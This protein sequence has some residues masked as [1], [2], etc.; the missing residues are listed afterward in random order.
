MSDINVQI[1]HGYKLKLSV[2]FESKLLDP[3]ILT[4]DWYQLIRYEEYRDECIEKYVISDDLTEM[5]K[6]KKW[7]IYILTSSQEDCDPDTSYCFIFNKEQELFN[8]NA[9]DYETGTVELF[10]EQPT[11]DNDSMEGQKYDIH[12]I[13]ESSY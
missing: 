11:N 10:Q 13:V 8:G 4:D 1:L 12:W 6:D 3:D 2:A 7:N 9:P 5:L